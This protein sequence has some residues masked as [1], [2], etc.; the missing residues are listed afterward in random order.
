VKSQL[1]I[2]VLA[3]LISLSVV[4]TASAV[5]FTIEISGG[6]VTGDNL[7]VV[8]LDTSNTYVLRDNVP[9]TTNVG[10]LQIHVLDPTVLASIL[11]GDLYP[12]LTID[13]VSTLF[14]L[15]VTYSTRFNTAFIAGSGPFTL[16]L[17]HKGLVTVNF[18][19]VGVLQLGIDPI[20]PI[21]AT[22]LYD[23]PGDP[24]TPAPEPGSLMLC[25]TGLVMASRRVRSQARR[26]AFHGDRAR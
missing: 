4:S 10:A 12:T 21:Q 26:L 1:S 18:P 15:Q 7:E 3:T 8:T 24:V 19:S 25:A 13:G 22:L 11:A 23:A 5:P 16:D 14:H 9:V 20:V 6:A 17:G 2:V